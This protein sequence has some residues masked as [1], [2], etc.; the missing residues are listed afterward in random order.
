MPAARSST[1]RNAPSAISS[2]MHTEFDASVPGAHTVP[3]NSTA[4]P[5]IVLKILQVTG[6][7]PGNAATVQFQVNDKSGNPVD[8]TKLTT[9]SMVIS[10]NNIDYG[11]QM[12]RTTEKPVTQA[13]GT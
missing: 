5:G 1:T 2:T 3:N 6:A 12:P 7:T 9:F 10:G 13:G 8:I 11:I 4:L